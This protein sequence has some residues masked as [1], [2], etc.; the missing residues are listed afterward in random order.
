MRVKEG[1]KTRLLVV[2]GERDLISYQ[3]TE[4]N[5]GRERHVQVPHP[6]VDHKF[7]SSSDKFT[8]GCY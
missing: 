1:Y 8:K 7:F 5:N 6:D 4:T 2:S 3:Q